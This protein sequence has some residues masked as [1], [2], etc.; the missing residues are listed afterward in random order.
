M[1]LPMVEDDLA[2]GA[3][4][5][6]HLPDHAGG[7]YGLSAIWRR[8]SPPGPAAAWLRDQFVELG[9]NDGEALTAA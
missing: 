1:P 9:R 7:R 5:R 8:E 4:V 2:S 6:L 3:L